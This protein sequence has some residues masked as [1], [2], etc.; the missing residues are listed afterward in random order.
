MKIFIKVSGQNESEIEKAIDIYNSTDLPNTE[1]YISFGNNLVMANMVTN[2]LQ[3]GF[4]ATY[5]VDSDDLYFYKKE[6]K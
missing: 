3:N 2:M 5:D 1:K 4:K 6:R